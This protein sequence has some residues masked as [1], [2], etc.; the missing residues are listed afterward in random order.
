MPKKVA[1]LCTRVTATR[2]PLLSA[3]RI[4]LSN[5]TI[6]PSQCDCVVASL[7][8]ALL[9]FQAFHK[10][11]DKQERGICSSRY[12]V[13]YAL[14]DSEAVLEELITLISAFRECCLQ[15]SPKTAILLTNIQQEFNALFQNWKTLQKRVNAFSNR[16]VV[17]L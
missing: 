1:C 16:I 15:A 10:F 4:V 14:V 7:Q 6:W 3:R 2:K 8:E 12:P 17:L 9:P 11:L 5:K 13:I